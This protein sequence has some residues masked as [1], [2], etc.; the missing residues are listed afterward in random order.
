MRNRRIIY[1]S[2][3]LS[4]FVFLQGCYSRVKDFDFIFREGNKKESVP[5]LERNHK[6]FTLYRLKHPIQVTARDQSPLF[7]IS[8]RSGTPFG[9]DILSGVDNILRQKQIELVGKLTIKD[10]INIGGGCTIWGFRVNKDVRVLGAGLEYMSGK[11]EFFTFDDGI[12]RLGYGVEFLSPKR[13]DMPFFNSFSLRCDRRFFKSSTLNTIYG[14]GVLQLFLRVDPVAYSGKASHGKIPIQL[15]IGQSSKN[16]ESRDVL[17]LSFTL[18]AKDHTIFVYPE[19]LGFIPNE[20]GN[21]S[22]ALSGNSKVRVLSSGMRRLGFSPLVAI[23]AD[24]GTIIDYNPSNWRNREFEVFSWNLFPGILIM[25]TAS[26]AIQSKF[27]KRL[28]FFTEKTGFVG[29]IVSEKL[30]EKRHG[31]NAHDYRAAN[32]AKFFNLAVSEGVN[33]NPYEK[34]LKEILVINGILKES[35][36]GRVAVGNFPGGGGII[37]FSR[38][39]SDFLRH[40]LLTHES[41]HGV[42]FSVPEYRKKCFDF[43]DSLSPIEKDFWVLFLE[44]KGYNVRRD[45]YLLVNEMQAY[46]FQQERERISPYYRDYVIPMMF[47]S[48]KRFN[49]GERYDQ[50]KKVV[51]FIEKN[52]DYFKKLHKRLENKLFNITGMVGGDVFI[53]KKAVLNRG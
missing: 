45:R 42:F 52:P 4:I 29:R 37:S 30:I 46:I 48:Y 1:L 3:L 6:N 36:A 21:L 33:L 51:D 12:L 8:Y 39:S 10:F 38:S 22:I 50:L 16:K 17:L 2:I 13:V 43:W 14:K 26:Y 40:L 23:P 11:G 41:Y 15:E 31:Y 44:W 49:Q 20:G 53:L 24:P 35:E 34:L 5:L 7:S 28:A 18:P 27:F 47:S 25:D 9:I 19:S 32:I